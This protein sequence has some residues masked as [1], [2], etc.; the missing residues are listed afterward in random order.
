M[1]RHALIGR[2]GA[3]DRRPIPLGDGETATTID[4]LNGERRLDHGIG[5]AIEDL[6]HL[7]VNPTEMGVDLLILG[8]LVHAAD[9]RVARASE[10][11]DGWTRELRV[12]VPV[13][14]PS[15]WRAAAGVLVTLLDFLT[16]DRWIVDFR[17][18]A[19]RVGSISAQER[20]R[21][22]RPRFDDLALFSGGMDSLIGA[23]D[24]LKE[25]RSPLLIS[26]AG[27]GATS[28][29]QSAL[30]DGLK[31][32][33]PRQHFERL[34]LWMAFPDD[35]VPGV[36]GENTTRG[37]SFLFFAL[38]VFAGTGLAG[39]ITLRGGFHNSRARRPAT[40]SMHAV[41]SRA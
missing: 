6:A 12:V 3:G 40:R 15:R 28:A 4:L 19:P 14:D 26:H 37:R 16:G 22:V 5:R 32:H 24:A 23:I 18:R 34:R 39:R 7:R 21:L 29:A 8:A 1:S 2:L 31:R 38:G 20:A 11:Q 17:R 25:G 35:L 9:T 10:S 27:E 13:S 30:F 33:F 41:W 36:A